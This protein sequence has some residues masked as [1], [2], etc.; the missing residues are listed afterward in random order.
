MCRLPPDEVA[1]LRVANARLHQVIEAKDTEVLVLREQLEVLRAEVADFAAT[2]QR[3]AMLQRDLLVPL[4]L[5]A[6]GGCA[7]LANR[8]GAISY[9]RSQL[10]LPGPRTAGRAHRHSDRPH[11]SYPRSAATGCTFA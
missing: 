10:P 9:L 7:E 2:P 3:L 6:L 8:A 5:M 4:E 1:A 11:R